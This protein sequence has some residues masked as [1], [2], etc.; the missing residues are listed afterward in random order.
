[1]DLSVSIVSYAPNGGQLQATLDSVQTAL[2][3][4]ALKAAVYLI[5]NGPAVSE[6]VVAA[7]LQSRP[8]SP[9]IAFIRIS[10]H[11]N[12][13]YGAG[14][15]LAIRQ[16][17]TPYHLVLNP[18]VE[19]CAD[20]LNQALT[21]M[22]HHSQAGLLAPAVYTGDGALQYLCRRYP[23]IRVL[24]LRGFAPHHWQQRHAQRLHHYE[25]RDV[26]G[27]DQVVWD[28]PMLSGCFMLLRRSVLQHT[29]GF[30]PR[31]FLYFE[32]YDLSVRVAAVARTV[33]VPRVRIVHHGGHAARKGRRHIQ[34]FI[35]S[36]LRF[37]HR[38]G[39]AW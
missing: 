12:I 27:A 25:M 32:D 5:D 20:A 3:Y 8:Q 21:F 28:I 24:A 13:G 19:L 34:Y 16:T 14:H 29:Q 39:W 38:H 17:D 10:G 23:G 4:A 9:S 35:R 6:P 33:Y 22:Q 36:A 18:D 2:D 26:I 37:Y 7:L 31:F 1:M 15:N 11:G 30:D